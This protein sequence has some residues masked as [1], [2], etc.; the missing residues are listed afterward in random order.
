MF[1]VFVGNGNGGVVTRGSGV[2]S[3]WCPPG[4]GVRVVWGVGFGV[5]LGGFQGGSVGVC[6]SGVGWGVWRAGGFEATSLPPPPLVRFDDDAPELFELL[7]RLVPLPEAL[8]VLATLVAAAGAVND[9][10][11]LVARA[12]LLSSADTVYM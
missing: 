12:P 2:S 8:L 1:G 4:L 7:A 10:A 5:W 3:P 9:I 6:A 11:G